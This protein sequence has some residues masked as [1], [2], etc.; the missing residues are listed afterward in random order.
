MKGHSLA[1]R[2][3]DGGKPEPVLEVIDLL[4]GET[5][6][7]GIRRF[8]DAQT[9]KALARR[10]VLAPYDSGVEGTPPGVTRYTFVADPQFKKELDAKAVPGD[11]PDPPCG[12]WGDQPDFIQYFEAHSGARKFLFVNVG[13]DDPLFDE[14]TLRI[15]PAK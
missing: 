1:M 8:F 3:S 15:L 13:Q 14:K 11:I 5:A 7:A 6:K 4:P 9:A 10:C 2:Y 12:K